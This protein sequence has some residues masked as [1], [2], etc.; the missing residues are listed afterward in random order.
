GRRRAYRR[1]RGRAVVSE[2]RLVHSADE[3]PRL[4]V[5]AAAHLDERRQLRAG[6][7][8]HPVL[9]PQRGGEG[10]GFE[11][12]HRPGGPGQPAAA[13]AVRRGR[14]RGH[15]LPNQPVLLAGRY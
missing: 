9:Q 14:P 12:I 5:A 2:H 3:A 7:Q 8:R 10:A 11:A 4:Q 6:Q 1:A 13:P 15:D